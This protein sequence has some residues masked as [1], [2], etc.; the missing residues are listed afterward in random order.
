MKK[1]D[2]L[3]LRADLDILYW[4]LGE[5]SSKVKE[6]NEFIKVLL[7]LEQFVEIHKVR[8]K[9]M[10]TYRDTIDKA[11]EEYQSLHLKYK[12]TK[13]ALEQTRKILNQ[14]IN[15]KMN[16]EDESSDDLGF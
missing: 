12:G 4:V 11:R 3:L 10:I 16:G 6:D 15:T 5:V 2:D 7:Q 14:V 8:T 1:A 9:D 13:E